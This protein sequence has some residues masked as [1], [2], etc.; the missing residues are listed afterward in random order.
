MIC[1]YENVLHPSYGTPSIAPATGMYQKAKLKLN[2]TGKSSADMANGSG[3]IAIP[4]VTAA[5]PATTAHLTTR[6]VGKTEAHT[7]YNNSLSKYITYHICNILNK[8]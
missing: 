5:V 2:N 1:L 6:K 7:N 8:F 3:Q 4:I